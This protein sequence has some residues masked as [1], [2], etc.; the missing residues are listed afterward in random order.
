MLFKI[1]IAQS[2]E[3]EDGSQLY[4]KICGGAYSWHT[5]VQVCYLQI[6]VMKEFAKYKYTHT[7]LYLYIF[8]LLKYE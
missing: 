7:H 1:S 2:F 4:F 6:M 3:L 8:D 5:I